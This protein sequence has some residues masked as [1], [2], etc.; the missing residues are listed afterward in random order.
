LCWEVEGEAASLGQELQQGGGFLTSGT[1]FLAEFVQRFAKFLRTE[2][3]FGQTCF[4][5]P[6]RETVSVTRS[7]EFLAESEER[8]DGVILFGQR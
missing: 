7:V 5:A 1:E 8:F 3:G 6:V 2:A 4:I